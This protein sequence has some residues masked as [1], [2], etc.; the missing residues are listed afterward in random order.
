MKILISLA[1]S[2]LISQAHA[3]DAAEASSDL[4]GR[5]TEINWGVN[6]TETYSEDA[7]ELETEKLNISVSYL[8]NWGRFGAG[9]GIDL[10]KSYSENATAIVEQESTSTIVSFIGRANFIEDAPGNDLIPYVGIAVGTGTSDTAGTST[11]LT[12]TAVALGLKWY[13]LSEIFAF[14]FELIP[15]SNLDLDGSITERKTVKVGMSLN[16]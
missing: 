11:G 12:S 8:R 16:F 4:R 13:P 7:N 6:Y 14:N 5:D 3:Q 1:V 2:L 15:Y 9:I 10:T